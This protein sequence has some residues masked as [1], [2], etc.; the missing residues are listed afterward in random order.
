MAVKKREQVEDQIDQDP[1]D[2]EPKVAKGQALFRTEADFSMLSEVRD[3]DI[4]DARGDWKA[5]TIPGFEGLIDAT[6][7]PEDDEA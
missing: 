1:G 2:G 7:E 4:R 6:M 5:R 3:R